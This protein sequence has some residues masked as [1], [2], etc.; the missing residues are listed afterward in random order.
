[1]AV[2]VTAVAAMVPAMQEMHQWTGEQNEVWNDAEQMGAV[3]LPE[4][5][6]RHGAKGKEHPSPR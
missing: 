4:Q 6:D 3:F 5:D 2:L 1:M